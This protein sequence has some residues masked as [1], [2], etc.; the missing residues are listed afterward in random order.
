MIQSFVM[1]YNDLKLSLNLPMK[2]DIFIESAHSLGRFGLL[3]AKSVRCFCCPL[4]M[5]ISQGSKGGPRGTK[6][7]P[8][9]ASVPCQKISIITTVSPPPP[10]VKYY[11]LLF[12]QEPYYEYYP[13]GLLAFKKKLLTT[14]TTFLFFW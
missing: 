11:S 5:S 9:V 2:G 6:P 10:L 12:G 7:S 4:F 1:M 14:I 13:C 3:V 8:T